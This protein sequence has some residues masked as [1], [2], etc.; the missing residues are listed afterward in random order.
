MS[1]PTPG[2]GAASSRLE[3]ISTVQGIATDP[4]A[5][6]LRYGPAIRGYAVRVLKSEN[7][8][9]DFCSEF[10]VRIL[11][12]KFRHWSPGEGRRFRDYLKRAVHNAL[13]D[14]WNR[15]KP[16]GNIE[17]RQPAELAA[18]PASRDAAAWLDAY[19]RAVLDL[20]LKALREYQN[21]RPGNVFH[22]LIQILE[23]SGPGD[24]RKLSARELVQKLHAATGREFTEEN[25]RQLRRR[26]CRKLGE[27]LLTEI[28]LGLASPTCADVEAELHE[29]GLMPYFNDSLLADWKEHLA[30]EPGSDP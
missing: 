18:C 30:E 16:W 2:C 26:A 11:E 13:A 19:R 29:L 6:V 28:R 20:A 12:G 15:K 5:M 9:D 8:A 21:Q 24:E 22:T 17:I 3:A 7:D 25:A 4:G 27:L 14:F 10:C 1:A 23:E